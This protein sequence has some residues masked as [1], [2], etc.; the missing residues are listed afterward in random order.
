MD[1]SWE[2][3]NWAPLILFQWEVD[4]SLEMS[5]AAFHS[6]TLDRCM[7][8]L[9]KHLL[10]SLWLQHITR[11]TFYSDDLNWILLVAR[12]AKTHGFNFFY[13]KHTPKIWITHLP[14]T[15][16]HPQPLNHFWCQRWTKAALSK[17]LNSLQRGSQAILLYKLQ[18]D[19]LCKIRSLVHFW[20]SCYIW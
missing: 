1:G 16:S 20:P 5:Q 18:F 15:G 10:R 2:H 12:L 17:A 13:W 8:K 19:P 3:L 14:Q 7:Q 6:P 4:I 9:L 11:N